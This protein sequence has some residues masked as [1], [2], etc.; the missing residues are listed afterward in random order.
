MRSTC[1]PDL[2]F[3]DDL[4]GLFDNIAGT[5]DCGFSRP[6]T[7]ESDGNLFYYRA[8]SGGNLVTA[9]ILVLNQT[10]LQYKAVKSNDED[11]PIEEQMI[12][13]YKR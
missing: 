2:I 6:F 5:T 9:E 4:S 1:T 3:N 12:R 7:W 8:L 10:T 13:K 11:I